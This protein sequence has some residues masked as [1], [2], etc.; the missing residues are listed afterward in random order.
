MS[1]ETEPTQLRQSLDAVKA[2]CRQALAANPE[3]RSFV[4]SYDIR[5]RDSQESPE[6]GMY[7]MQDGVDANSP[8]VDVTFGALE[9]TQHVMADLFDRA[10]QSHLSLR[11]ETYDSLQELIKIRNEIAQSSSTAGR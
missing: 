5:G 8:P 10:I 4:V 11:Q 7:V 3:I 2:A 9:V 1:Y 6:M